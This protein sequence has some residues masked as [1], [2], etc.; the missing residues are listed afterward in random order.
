MKTK[1]LRTLLAS[2]LLPLF[3]GP[4]RASIAY[5]SINNFDTVNDTGHE[6]H[7]FEIE[8]DDCH[9]TD[10]TYTYNYNH[11]GVPKLTEDNSVPGHP[12]CIIRWESKKNADGS[13]AAYTAIPAGPI[14]ATNGHM[15]T[16]PA[17]NFGGEHF[18]VGY[19]VQPTAVL[20]NWLIDN[21]AGALTK[22]GA[23]QVSTP[24]F[25]YYPPVAVG[26]PVP[27]Q[28]QAVIAPPPPPVP[29]PLQFGDAVWVKEIK[30]RTHNVNKVKLRELVSDD[31][32]NPNDK[33][34]KNG[35]PD[36]VEVEWRILQ[37]NNGLAD[38]GVNNQ[39]P[40]AAED[41]PG[42]NEVVTRRYEFFK[43]AGPLDAETGEAMGDLVGPDGIHGSGTVTYADHFSLATF[44][45]VTVTVDMATETVVGD[46][47]GAQ[48]AAVD[49]DAAVGLIEHVSEGK[50]NTAYTARTVV[51]QG[52]LPFTAT[53]TGSLP[54]GMAFNTTTGVLSGTP[55]ASGQF[56][57]QVTATDGVN[58]SVSKNYTLAVAAP[59]V[60][61]APAS[62]LDTVASP[63]G[64]GTTMGDGSFVPGA[65]VTVNATANAG[66]RFVNW[67]DNGAVVSNT[68]GFTLTL[69]V[70][71]SLVA[72]FAPTVMPRTITL[73]AQPVAGGLVNGGGTV[74]DGTS[75]TVEAV[76]A[77]G[78]AFVNWTEAAAVVSAA[79]SYTFT[80][81]ADRA[82]IAN[83]IPA[84]DLRTVTTVAAPL[85]GGAT[86][87]GGSFPIGTSI[88]VSAVPAVGYKFKRWLEGTSNRSTSANYT[89]TVDR[90][91]ALSAKFV[92]AALIN[93]S[94]VPANAGATSGGGLF[95]D[96][97]N[98]TVTATPVAGATFV[99]WTENGVEIAATTSFTFKARPETAPVRNLIANFTAPGFAITAGSGF[100]A[101]GNVTGSGN[102]LN[103]TLVTLTATPAARYLFTSWT[104]NGVIV[105]TSPV[106]TFQATADSTLTANFQPIVDFVTVAG[107]GPKLSWPVSAGGWQLQENT[108]LSGPWITSGI[109][110]TQAGDSSEALLPSDP[111][112]CFFRLIHP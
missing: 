30:T 14:S 7:G 57:F 62:L 100:P 95:E 88:T 81:A 15:F 55:T 104:A 37:K 25:T 102:F 56:N 10:I 83:F 22:G 50:Q 71:H 28:V 76:A 75:V 36:E 11:Y 77:P 70:N 12:K 66:F 67:T 96:G 42:G 23:V 33:N 82:L 19:R 86:S 6:C 97:D 1:T 13:W 101:G 72:N 64:S 44:E 21:G 29:P 32:V 18:G 4:A 17:V 38:G 5:G 35:E 9:S 99:N 3:T 47:T 69:D 24:T 68:P 85:A 45:W 61:L 58:P 26:N 112:R 48:M 109:P 94:A 89:F 73:S 90:N 106:Y 40:A 105:C 49:V 110:V 78:F 8:L 74:D 87:G 34:W 51:V 93:T 98:V 92:V 2:L 84:G 41:L 65:N 52:S 53:R 91:V 27:A 103:G 80:A 54:T 46:F 60:A 79:A 39:V 107:S 16:N 108:D 111:P 20:Y 63:A 31:P 43:Y 59:G